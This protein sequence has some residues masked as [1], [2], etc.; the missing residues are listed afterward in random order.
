MVRR[1]AI[2]L[3]CI[4][5]EC[6]HEIPGKPHNYYYCSPACEEETER[7]T[8]RRPPNGYTPP[9]VIVEKRVYPRERIRGNRA[10]RH[11]VR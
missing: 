9:E 8:I 2:L 4:N 6:D 11:M 10:A 7:L 1:C 3:F 5:P